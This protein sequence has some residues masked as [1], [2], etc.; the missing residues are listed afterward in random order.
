M[1]QQL[2]RLKLSFLY[3]SRVFPQVRNKW[4]KNFDKRPYRWGAD[5]TQGKV[6]VTPAS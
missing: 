1:K 6:N 5:F 4:S 3:I 2:A